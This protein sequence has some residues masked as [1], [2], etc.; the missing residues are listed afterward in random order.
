ML[1]IISDLHLT[2]GTSGTTIDSNAFSIFRYRLRDLAYAASWRKGGK[3][4][5]IEDLNVVLLGDIFDLIRS[6]KWLEGAVRPWDN[7]NDAAFTSRIEEI[8][9]GIIA[10]NPYSLKTLRQLAS[11]K[12]ITVPR[13]RPVTLAKASHPTPEAQED[14][15]AVKVKFYYQVGNHDWFYRLPGQLYD[16][17]RKSVAEA[18]GLSNNPE[19]PF[20]YYPSECPELQEIYTQHGVYACHGDCYDPMNFDGDR[21]KSSIGDG[22][23][24]DI[25]TRFHEE[26]RKNLAARL[27]KAVVDG[28]KEIDNVRPL[29]RIPDWIDGLLRHACASEAQERRVKG[30]WDR[31]A[32]DF[33]DSPV[34]SKKYSKPTIWLMK[35]G[36]MF[37]EGLSMKALG[38]LVKFFGRKAMDA[39]D[40]SFE[41]ALAEK[42]FRDKT[43][44]SI[45]YGHTHDEKIIPLDLSMDGGKLLSQMYF[46]TGTWRRVFKMAVA[47]PKQQEFMSHNVMTYVAFYKGDE[48]YGRPY[49]AWTGT[50]G[51]E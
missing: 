20:P 19:K 40:P 41:D 47:N 21:G 22:I 18:M 45:V 7:P 38:K 4:L 44:K 25:I 11:G 8:N 1:V 34:V 17:L 37:S 33:L 32:G 43:A 36:L 24:I 42:A 50:L 2:D 16:R 51:V 31:I 26:V 28:L 6:T 49:E 48:R 12:D 35:A 13:R 30:V 10:R 3:Y 14:D 29:T 27:P 9:K 46:N 15:P 23:V 5:P 39:E